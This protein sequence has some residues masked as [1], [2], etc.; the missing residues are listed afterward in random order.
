VA[1][2]LCADGSQSVPTVRTLVVD[3]FEPFRR[4][5]CS[6]L[7]GRPG[8]QVIG[9]AADGLEAVHKAR[10]LKPDLILLDIGLPTLD[11]IE[12]SHR[13]SRVVP[14]SK[15]LFITQNN[16]PDLVRAVLGNSGM[17]YVLK[18]DAK[19]EL[20]PAVEAVLRDERFVST[21]VN[22]GD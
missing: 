16:D 6:T 20:L 21:G 22:D 14:D 3:D 13:I 2:I 9:E 18:T 12:A 5:V 17:G 11:G 8:L 15:I 4:F 10:E 19:R 1:T 7:E